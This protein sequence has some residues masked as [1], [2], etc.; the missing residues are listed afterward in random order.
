[1]RAVGVDYGRKR[2]GLAVSDATG[3]LAR[4]LKTIERKGDPRAV[5]AAIAAEV[6]AVDDAVSA[7]VIGLP[8]R[9]S[10]EATDQTAAVEQLIA[11]LRQIVAVPVVAQDERLTSREAE[12]VLA[13]REKDWRKRKANIDAMA[14]AIILQDYLDA[15]PRAAEEH[16][17]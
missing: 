1:V 7:I 4:P 15:Q 11:A 14:A 6:A 2:I 12:R 3:M 9:L 8:R 10:G 13:E 5:A 17:Q 16:E